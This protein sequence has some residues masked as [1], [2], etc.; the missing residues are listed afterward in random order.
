MPDIRYDF[1]TG[2]SDPGT[3]PTEAL[4]AAA[5]KVIEE[6]AEELTMYPGGLGHAG[7]R[8]AMA[9][10]EGEREGVAI[11]P[12]HIVLT[13]GSMQAVTLTAEA[14]QEDKG[15]KDQTQNRNRLIGEGQNR[16]VACQWAHQK[17]AGGR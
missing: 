9:R 1:G 3:F 11:D 4:K 10:R 6:Q 16:A 15:D 5:V 14:L 2:R 8:A 12:D 13:D 7:L 17:A